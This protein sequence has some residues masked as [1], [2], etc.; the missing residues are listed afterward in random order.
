MS[1]VGRVVQWVGSVAIWGGA[2]AAH[3]QN[4]DAGKS[5]AQ[6]FSETCNACHRSPRELK[7]TTPRFMQEH[8]TT[9]GREAAAMA[10]YLASVGTDPRAVKL[11]RPPVL[12]AGQA[13]TETTVPQS[14]PQE[15]GQTAIRPR[16][17]VPPDIDQAELPETQA[18]PQTPLGRRKTPA[19]AEQSK[20]SERAKSS[21]GAVAA[22]KPRRPSE[23]LE[24][25][26]LPGGVL[27]EGDGEGTPPQTV[28][29][30]F[31]QQNSVDNFEE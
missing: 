22:G 16:Q 30:P 17:S 7:Q 11:R 26:K 12:G 27:Q 6:V 19:A 23:S 28:V 14:P 25:S 10:A 3:A 8:Y 2:A 13:P 5:P 9:S 29:T 4:L 18:L 21:Q 31:R 24:V 1:K 20:P 15:T